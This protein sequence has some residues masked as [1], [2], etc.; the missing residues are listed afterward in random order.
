MVRR[1]SSFAGSTTPL[2]AITTPQTKAPKMASSP[3]AWV[4]AELNRTRATAAATVG[5]ALS[6]RSAHRSTVR[7]SGRP[8]TA[9]KST[10]PTG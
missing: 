6:E 9:A 3:I 8:I 1:G 7:T 10:T 2:V 4:A 5:M